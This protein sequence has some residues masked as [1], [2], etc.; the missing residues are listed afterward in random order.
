MI[1]GLAGFWSVLFIK[2]GLI[3]IPANQDIRHP[4]WAPAHLFA[5]GI[6]RDSRAAFNN[7][8]IMDVTDNEAVREITHGE[9]EGVTADSLD[10]VL[11][12]FGAVGFDAFPLLCGT[13]AFIGDG[14]PAEPVFPDLRLYVRKVPARREGNEEH[15]AFTFKTDAVHVCPY[16]LPDGGFHGGI[17]IPPETL[18]CLGWM[19][20][21]HP[22]GGRSSFS[23]S[24]ISRAPIEV[25]APT[26]P[27]YPRASSAIFPFCRRW[28]LMPCFS[29]GTWNIWLALAQ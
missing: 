14:I 6:Q 8:F 15:A 1:K 21:M 19:R 28:L 10:D 22:Q 26:D 12:E 7:E 11:Y 29:T 5:Y 4:L 3:S 2:R 27:P 25:R 23:E 17:N 13:H 9:A 24:P 18:R 20:A 16:A